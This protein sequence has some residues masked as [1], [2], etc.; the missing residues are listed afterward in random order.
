MFTFIDHV[1]SSPVDI[2][3]QLKKIHHSSRLNLGINFAFPI[4]ERK[5]T[6]LPVG[7]ISFQDYFYFNTRD[8]EL[9]MPWFNIHYFVPTDH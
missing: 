6:H 5:E 1:N 9:R 8:F 3:I 2:T 7:L 4:Y